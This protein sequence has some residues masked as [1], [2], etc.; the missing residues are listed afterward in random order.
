VYVLGKTGTGKST[1]AELMA[2]QD[3]RHGHGVCFIDPKGAHALHLLHYVPEWRVQ[4][5]FYLEPYEFPIPVSLMD[6]TDNA[7]ANYIAGDLNAIFRKVSDAIAPG[8]TWGIVMHSLLQ[9]SLRT[10]RQF[11]AGAFKGEP[12]NLLHIEQLLTDD[13]WREGNVGRFCDRDTKNYWHTQYKAEKKHQDALLRRLTDFRTSD[14][15]KTLFTRPP[16]INVAEIMRKNQ[17]LIINLGKVTAVTDKQ[18]IGTILITKFQQAA[19]RRV[20]IPESEWRLFLLFVD[21]FQDFTASPLGTILRQCRSFNLGLTLLHQ[22]LVQEGVDSRTQSSIL[23]ID[24]AVIFKPEDHDFS[25]LNTKL[26]PQYEAG[27][28]ANLVTEEHKAFFRSSSS[29]THY[30]QT[31]PLPTVRESH[32]DT[33]LA[34]MRNLR[35]RPSSHA[36]VGPV[37]SEE[38]ET[39]VKQPPSEIL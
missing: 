1:L 39:D 31:F 17:I 23:G 8:S 2:L 12:I 33:I 5:T 4:D 14:T 10:L 37:S 29:G 19:M 6:M 32:R 16:K 15:L 27:D 38:D 24:T 28:L 22:S 34:N 21:E 26:A 13:D 18:I 36:A 11:G 35:D 7:E 3:I 25:H 9:F 30:I 20:Y